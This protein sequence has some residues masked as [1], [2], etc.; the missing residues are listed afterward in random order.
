MYPLSIHFQLLTA[1]YLL[2]SLCHTSYRFLLS[3]RHTPFPVSLWWMAHHQRAFSAGSKVISTSHRDHISAGQWS[4]DPVTCQ[5][6]LKQPT[7]VKLLYQIPCRHTTHAHIHT[8][9]HSLTDLLDIPVRGAEEVSG[10]RAAP[11]VRARRWC[12]LGFSWQWPLCRNLWHKL[13][14]ASLRL[15][16][17]RM[18]VSVTPQDSRYRCHVPSVVSQAVDVSVRNHKHAVRVWQSVTWISPC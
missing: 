5:P 16:S 4:F 8:L 14:T 9:I 12:L 3:W 13:F 6:F 7:G 11:G 1:L 10:C 15:H 18:V 17:Q 2:I